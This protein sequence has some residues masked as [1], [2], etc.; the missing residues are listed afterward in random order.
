MQPQEYET[1]SLDQTIDVPT[2]E[3][4]SELDSDQQNAPESTDGLKVIAPHSPPN[5]HKC[6]I[7]P[8][9]K[10]FSAWI[11]LRL[12]YKCIHPNET[13][14]CDLCNTT[15]LSS[16]IHDYGKSVPYA[17]PLTTC[18]TKYVSEAALRLHLETHHPGIDS[19]CIVCHKTIPAHVEHR[20]DHIRCLKPADTVQLTSTPKKIELR[21]KSS[22][23]KRLPSDIFQCRGCCDW[24]LKD[25][26]LQQ[27]CPMCKIITPVEPKNAD[28][29]T[30]PVSARKNDVILAV[31]SPENGE[32]QPNDSY[33]CSKCSAWF[34]RDKFF[35]HARMY[36]GK[37]K[38]EGVVVQVDRTVLRVP[39]NHRSENTMSNGMKR[40]QPPIHNYCKLQGQQDSNQPL[41]SVKFS[42]DPTG[43]M[44]RSASE[45]L[46]DIIRMAADVSGV[47]TEVPTQAFT[48]VKPYVVQPLPQ[49]LP[50][51]SNVQEVSSVPV[52]YQ[53]G[54]EGLKKVED[55]YQS[56]LNLLQ[57]GKPYS[58]PEPFPL[59][60]GSNM[61]PLQ[62]NFAQPHYIKTEP[63][64]FPNYRMK[65]F[66]SP[67]YNN[68]YRYVNGEYQ[69]V[70][71]TYSKELNQRLMYHKK[72]VVLCE[73]DKAARDK[74]YQDNDVKLRSILVTTRDL[75]K[76]TKIKVKFSS[77]KKLQGNGL[78][79]DYVENVKK[80]QFCLRWIVGLET[81]DEHRYYCDPMGPRDTDMKKMFRCKKC[82]KFFRG[83]IWLQR[84]LEKYK[85][86]DC[87]GRQENVRK[88]HARD[89]PLR[90]R[91]CH[92]CLKV[93]VS[94]KALRSHHYQS[95]PTTMNAL[96]G[97]HKKC[98][99]CANGFTSQTEFDNHV[100]KSKK[101]ELLLDAELEEKEKRKQKKVKSP[102]SF[103]SEIE[104]WKPLKKPK[105]KPSLKKS[106]KKS[107]KKKTL[108]VLQNEME[109]R[110][111]SK[112]T[113]IPGRKGIHR[114]MMP[115]MFM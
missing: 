3:I 20:Q 16:I 38:D 17:C 109:E 8:C 42:T 68:K 14:F 71:Y 81:F 115:K 63:C 9:Q 102:R 110:K 23:E 33:Q 19:Y 84:H 49:T 47:P 85:N 43:N 91:Q 51:A 37:C 41:T 61:A 39:A 4:Q 45:T 98:R 112:N 72:P 32:R 48:E 79:C 60:N 54:I 101:W 58:K 111:A 28:D 55:P 70:Y 97:A 114:V 29:R 1:I 113:M 87:P 12:H 24:F 76:V 6:R 35:Q 89:K 40:E 26:L 75:S 34:P 5:Q 107:K 77:K 106:L 95:P 90:E 96:R 83:G 57:S 93:F 53:Q 56:C 15:H 52:Y 100:I 13:I 27:Y 11:F 69:P 94:K 82:C 7:F 73:E 108:R 18:K 25:K 104:D 88:W 86:R 22:Y 80:C 64:I 103:E 65:Q 92:R 36:Q 78:V 66:K 10:A 99:R 44:S 62:N 105:E 46:T 30:K 31:N 2:C 67:K 74:F 50:I 59:Y 21:E